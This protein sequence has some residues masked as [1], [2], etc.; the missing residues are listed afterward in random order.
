M[1]GW[2]YYGLIE[3]ARAISDSAANRK[4]MSNEVEFDFEDRHA[5]ICLMMAHFSITR[6]IG[7]PAVWSTPHKKSPD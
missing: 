3:F 6:V 1:C 5:P 2:E 4:H 7:R